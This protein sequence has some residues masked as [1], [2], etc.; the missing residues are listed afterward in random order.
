MINRRQWISGTAGLAFSMQASRAEAEGGLR[1]FVSRLRPY[2]SRARR[3][4]R[5]GRAG[6]RHW[7]AG[8]LPPG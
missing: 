8:G 6:H 3:Q 2:R 5:R 4:T 7:I 1:Q